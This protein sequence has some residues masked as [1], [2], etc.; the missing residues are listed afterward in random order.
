MEDEQKKK[1]ERRREH[2]S[3]DVPSWFGSLRMT[4]DRKRPTEKKKKKKKGGPT[5]C[6]QTLGKEKSSS[7]NHFLPSA[8]KRIKTKRE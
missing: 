8:I 5:G 3:G 6:D 7:V 2:I 1:K 4:D